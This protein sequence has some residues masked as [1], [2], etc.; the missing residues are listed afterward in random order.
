MVEETVGDDGRSAPAF[1]LRD[2][3]A[4]LAL[5]AD[6]WWWW[7]YGIAFYSI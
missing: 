7:L 2:A 3:D 6:Q 5:L 4:A 1:S